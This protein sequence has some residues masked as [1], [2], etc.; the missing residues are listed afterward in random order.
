MPRSISVLLAEREALF[1]RG[2]ATC[3]EGD[4]RIAIVASVE[5]ARDAYSAAAALRPAVA[6]VGTTLSDQPGS[7]PIAKLRLRLPALQI[8]ALGLSA[9]GD[10]VLSA[11]EAGAR[12]FITKDITEEELLQVVVHVAAADRHEGARPARPS[13]PTLRLPRSIADLSMASEGYAPMNP[14]LTCREL[15]I[16]R[17]IS[18]GF[19]NAEVGQ[20]LGISA[21]TVKN[22]VTAI[23]RKLEVSDRTQ[24]VVLAMRRGWVSMDEASGIEPYQRAPLLPNLSVMPRR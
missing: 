20:A 22:H 11:L 8:I 16:L 13:P 15:E 18:R 19:T 9:S 21:Q 6:I 1:R 12:T 2:L 5:T 7:E 14:P 3:L 10:A 4:Q 24:A 17:S 23:L